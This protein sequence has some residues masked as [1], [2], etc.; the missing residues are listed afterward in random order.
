MGLFLDWADCRASS[1][2]AAQPTAAGNAN[3]G[4]PSAAV[5]FWQEQ[6]NTPRPAKANARI[7][8]AEIQLRD[9]AVTPP[10]REIVLAGEARSRVL[11]SGIV[12]R[13]GERPGSFE[14]I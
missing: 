10:I 4:A 14:L 1:S 11:F 3:V 7:I 8:A 2:D 5:L 12:Q 13:N 9:I 6:P